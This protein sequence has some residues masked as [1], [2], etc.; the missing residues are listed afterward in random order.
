MRRHFCVGGDYEGRSAAVG[1]LGPPEVD[2][3]ETHRYTY[4]AL[5]MPFFALKNIFGHY[6]RQVDNLRA[7]GHRGPIF[8]NATKPHILILKY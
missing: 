4:L 6:S 3:S 1:Y 7:S 5:E 2:F 8:Q